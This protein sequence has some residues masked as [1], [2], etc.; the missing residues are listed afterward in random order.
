MA[1]EMKVAQAALQAFLNLSQSWRL[2]D[3]QEQALLGHPPNSIFEKWKADKID[4]CLGADT[5]VRISCLLGIAKSLHMLLPGKT[6]DDWIKKPNLAPLFKGQ[7]ALKKMLKGGL[8]DLVE[9]HRYL[10]TECA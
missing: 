2:S 8:S 7:S 4:D 5:L 10:E 1:E 9:A 6:A 3:S